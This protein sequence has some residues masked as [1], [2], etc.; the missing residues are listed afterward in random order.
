MSKGFY[1]I[2]RRKNHVYVEPCLLFE[3]FLG[4]DEN[5]TGV[6]EENYNLDSCV[7]ILKALEVNG[8]AKGVE[9]EREE[10]DDERCTR[11]VVAVAK[12][13]KRSG[14]G[15]CM[16]DGDELGYGQRDDEE[17]L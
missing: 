1:I 9:E 17:D 15:A 12:T 5:L 10:E 4:C 6:L 3:E 16:L 2:D 14:M 13:S 11:A 7:T 8:K